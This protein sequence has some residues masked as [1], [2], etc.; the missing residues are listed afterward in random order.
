MAWWLIS[1][2]WESLTLEI[3]DSNVPPNYWDGAKYSTNPVVLDVDYS[4]DTTTWTYTG[5]SSDNMSDVG[6]YTL[7]LTGTDSFGNIATTSQTI[8]VGAALVLNDAM[9]GVIPAASKGFNVTFTDPYFTIQYSATQTRVGGY[10]NTPY[11]CGSWNGAASDPNYSVVSP[12]GLTKPQKMTVP[13]C[14]IAFTLSA[15]TGQCSF[16]RYGSGYE[17]NQSGGSIYRQHLSP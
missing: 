1:A 8:S 10:T 12:S 9:G 17:W 3:Y 16:D 11:Y 7:A 15:N 6:A 13:E 4:A 2:P 14:D 5:F